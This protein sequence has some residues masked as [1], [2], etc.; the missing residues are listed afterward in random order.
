MLVRSIVGVVFV[1]LTLAGCATPGGGTD[2]EYTESTAVASLR[3]TAVSQRSA[4]QL[5]D[6]QATLERAL[7]IEPENARLWHQLAAVHMDL[8]EY[9]Q[10]ENMALRATRYASG[11]RSMQH[12]LWTLIAKARN[13]AGDSEGARAARERAAGF[14]I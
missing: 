12:S 4:G 2:G 3:K 10:A 5:V 9:Q 6:A 11:N 8:G 14:S 13:A 7:R 1:I